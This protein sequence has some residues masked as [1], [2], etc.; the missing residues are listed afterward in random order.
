MNSSPVAI[1]VKQGFH[2]GKQVKAQEL[3]SIPAFDEVWY[4]A[5]Q[6]LKANVFTHLAV[7]V[8][9]DVWRIAVK[10]SRPVLN[11]IRKTA[12]QWTEWTENQHLISS[13]IFEDVWNETG[14]L[15]WTNTY[16]QLAMPVKDE[17]GSMK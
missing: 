11:R 10:S 13:P 9:M 1:L 8:Q 3:I 14:T 5:G 2:W 16:K 4:G 17:I 7:P 6:L 15:L 12:F